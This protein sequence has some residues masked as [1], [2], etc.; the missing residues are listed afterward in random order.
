MDELV[1]RLLPDN[2]EPQELVLQQ[3]RIS[4]S[5]LD[6]AN[7]TSAYVFN[8]Y[9]YRAQIVGCHEEINNLV[10]LLNGKEVGINYVPDTGM[11]YFQDYSFG[12]RIFLECY[13][14]VQITIIYDDPQRNQQIKD[15]E[16]IHVL[17][18][19]GRQN[20]SV[21]R[22]T[23]YVYKQNADLLHGDRTLPKD[24]S[25][26]KESA[27]KT[28]ESHI[29]LLKQI[30]VTY[31]E[32]F[33]YFKMNSRFVTT[34]KERVDHFEKLQYV[35]R[36]TLQYIAQHPEELQRVYHS[37]GIQ[38]GNF[39]YQPNKTLITDNE[40]SYDIYENRVVLGF[41]AFLVREIVRIE[42]ELSDVVSRVPFKITETDGYV[43][44]SYFIYEKT[45][46]AI[47]ILLGDIRDLHRRFTS[48]YYLYAEVF[49]IKPEVISA[50][51]KFTPLFRAIPQYH[52]IFD[53]A[54][55]WFSKGVFTIREE[56]FML[57]FIKIST[58]YEVYV[59]AK[60][61]NY[62]KNG[63]Y[64]LVVA[65]KVPY[66]SPGRYY[67]NTYCNNRFVFKNDSG[68]ITVYYQPVI[69]NTNRKDVSGIGLYRNTSISFPKTNDG[70]K[71]RGR[72]YTP[73]FLIKYEY[74]GQS[75]EKYLIMDAKFSRI[76]TVKNRELAELAYKYLFSISP[77]SK[78]G[79]ILGMCIFNG[80]SESETQ[81]DGSTNI[82]DFELA[83]PITPCANIVT[84]T[85]NAMNAEALHEALLKNAI[86]LFVSEI[87]LKPVSLPTFHSAETSELQLVVVEPTDA[88]LHDAS[89]KSKDSSEQI[90]S[91]T[92]E[93]VATQTGGRTEELSMSLND[94]GKRDIPKKKKKAAIDLRELSISKLS[95]DKDLEA[96][97]LS[98]GYMT[99]QDL[100]PNKAKNDLLSNSI[101]NRKNRR[102][103]EAKLKQQ[104]IHLR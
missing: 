82:Y 46:D 98:A 97:L 86:G 51:P 48:L 31:E 50:V 93:K 12:Q 27:R 77:I 22:M 14:F 8:D 34:P 57:S 16:Y 52:Q 29:L 9:K 18:R 28:I 83:N 81:S 59:L 56:Q 7:A 35:S 23:E 72:Y 102:E 13:G 94:S 42:K 71:H 91:T 45:I 76:E 89:S 5:I 17:V 20:E 88:E 41:L 101:L 87:P 62:F 3:H 49:P 67:E 4:T 78:E 60:L 33:R 73:D 6:T 80:I 99:I 32:N 58:L 37:S 36:N 66:P 53:C 30:S 40:K 39:R 104:K 74:I 85:E 65:D 26:L 96:R 69:Y 10:F 92:V 24:I 11:I 54:V 21:R 15:T 84:L 44:S 38:I 63:G 43:T 95:L 70:A 68:Q 47:K 25:G 55:A 64:S 19:K 2:Q 103:I 100:V 75:L 90:F 61:I 79:H 1:L